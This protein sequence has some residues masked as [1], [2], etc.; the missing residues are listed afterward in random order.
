MD[1]DPAA[2]GDHA[3]INARSSLTAGRRFMAKLL[4]IELGRG[5]V[6]HNA[7]GWSA[8]RICRHRVQ[9]DSSGRD[10]RAKELRR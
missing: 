6:V 1:D 8:Q 2:L 4:A 7:F 3:G 10:A 5:Q 9:R